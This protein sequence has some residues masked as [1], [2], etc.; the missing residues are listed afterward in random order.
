MVHYYYVT[1]V[2][3]DRYVTNSTHR[4]M[5]IALM[6]PFLLL[7]VVVLGAGAAVFSALSRTH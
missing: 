5:T 4:L 7:S 2:T 3:P 6:K 1:L